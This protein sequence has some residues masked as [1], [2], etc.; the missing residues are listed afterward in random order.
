MFFAIAAR[1]NFSTSCFGA[2]IAATEFWKLL[3]GRHSSIDLCFYTV[4]ASEL[5]HT[6]L[7]LGTSASSDDFM[8]NS[9]D[10]MQDKPKS[11]MHQ[12]ELCK[13]IST[14]AVTTCTLWVVHNCLRGTFAKD[15]CPIFDAPHKYER[16]GSNNFCIRL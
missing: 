4:T 10:T 5:P 13:W 12:N 1:Y 11:H 2:K 15:K 14:G 8:E 3:M 6:L 16:A 7:I 9:L